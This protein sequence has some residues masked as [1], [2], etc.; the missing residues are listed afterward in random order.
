M[1]FLLVSEKPI[2]SKVFL[3]TDSE[4]ESFAE[5]RP[6]NQVAP[7]TK[8]KSGSTKYTDIGGMAFSWRAFVR[9]FCASS[10][11]SSMQL[12]RA[13]SYITVEF[14]YDPPSGG[15]VCAGRVLEGAFKVVQSVF[16]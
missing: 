11:L 1:S 15:I 4:L 3:S 10:N 16:E 9:N 7:R 12:T 5:P 6:L 13:R 14:F 2:D 8:L